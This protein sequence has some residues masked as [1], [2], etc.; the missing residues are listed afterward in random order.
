MLHAGVDEVM[1]PLLHKY[2][3]EVA[4]RNKL[5][6]EMKAAMSEAKQDGVEPSSGDSNDVKAEIKT[7]EVKNEPKKSSAPRKKFIWT[8]STR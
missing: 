8:A 6:Q 3:E 5:R 1:V 2:K 4:E 7:P